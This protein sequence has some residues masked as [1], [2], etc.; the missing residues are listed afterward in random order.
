[1]DQT[2]IVLCRDHQLPL[3]V[4]DITQSGSL[5]RIAS[6]DTSVGTIVV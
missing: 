1:M 3:C 5:A 4:Y 2:A 6:G